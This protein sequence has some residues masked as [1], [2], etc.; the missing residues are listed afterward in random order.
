[1]MGVWPERSRDRERGSIVNTYHV[2]YIDDRE[3]PGEAT[4][5]AA[6]R[7]DAGMALQAQATYEGIDRRVI[8]GITPA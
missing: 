2:T 8:T 4:V 1:M 5:Q 3:F 7:F 6:S